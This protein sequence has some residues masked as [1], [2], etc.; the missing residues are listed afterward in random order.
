MTTFDDFISSS[1]CA[2]PVLPLVHLTD[3]FSLRIILGEG[4]L[5]PQDCPVIEGPALYFSYGRPAFRPNGGM[6]PTALSSYAPVCFVM[7]ASKVPIKHVFP[8][9]TGAFKKRMLAQAFHRKMPLKSFEL[10]ADLRRPQQ[11]VAK[12]FGSNADYY[13][14]S[15][16]PSVAVPSLL[17][18]AESVLSLFANKQTEE[19]DDRI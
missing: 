6:Q 5:K 10:A 7:D 8:F 3:G 16:N 9:D 19:Y 15:V 13:D 2:D 17:F 11:V 14:C 18:E 12:F 1:P 4:E